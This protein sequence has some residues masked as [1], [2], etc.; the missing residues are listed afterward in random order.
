MDFLRMGGLLS[1]TV[2]ATLFRGHKPTTHRMLH[3]GWQ[4]IWPLYICRSTFAVLCSVCYTSL[5]Q[6][7]G[8]FLAKFEN[9]EDTESLKLPSYTI[10]IS[11]IFQ[12]LKIYFFVFLV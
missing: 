8:Q 5:M 10:F 2:T 4:S 9:S 6:F 3:V 11:K 7:F 12:N 1:G